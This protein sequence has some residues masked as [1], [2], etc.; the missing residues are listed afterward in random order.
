MTG[1]A[2]REGRVPGAIHDVRPGVSQQLDPARLPLPEPDV[3]N[4][5]TWRLPDWQT[6]DRTI[7]NAFYGQDTWTRNRLSVQGA[8][9]Y[10][11]A[12]SFSPA[13][14]NGTQVTS[15]FNAAP[16]TLERTDGVNTYRDISPRVG[17]AYDVFGNGKTAVKFNLGRYLA[18]ATN[19]TIYTANNPSTR[20][21]NDRL[22]ELDGHQQELR[23]RLRHPQPGGADRPGWRHVRRADRRCAELRQARGLDAGEPGPAERAGASGR[24]TGS[25]A[26]TCSRSSLPRVSL[27]VGYNRRWWGNFTVTDN[28]LVG[29]SDYQKWTII[30][31]KDSR[32]P[33]G[34]GYPVDVYTLTQPR[35][36]LGA[37][38]IT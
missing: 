26:S 29:P 22:A 32:L 38:T 11:Q 31:P 8:L 28:T 2:Q 15:R 20:I 25:G 18:P 34:G 5:V 16:I 37:R 24:S 1:V 14:G 9:R 17:V 10:D 7:P 13:E 4:Q 21:V 27:E 6:S 35:R 12:S 36:R 30:A 33:G 3:P 23:R 19:D